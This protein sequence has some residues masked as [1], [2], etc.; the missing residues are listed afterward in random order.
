MLLSDKVLADLEVRIRA[1]G[2]R[3]RKKLSAETKQRV[4]GYK[5]QDAAKGFERGD[6]SDDLTPQFLFDKLE[7]CDFTCVGC[8]RPLLKWVPEDKGDPENRLWT[9]DRD[10]N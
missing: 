10:D 3:W 8:E 4:A 6:P 7:E 9:W 1:M 2:L 5:A